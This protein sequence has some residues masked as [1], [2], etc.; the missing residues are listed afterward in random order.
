MH[1]GLHIQ[2]RIFLSDLKFLD[3]FSEKNSQISNFMKIHP[4]G[5]EVSHP[6]GRTDRQ[7]D[8]TKLTVAV[9]SFATTT[10]EK[11]TCL[12][13]DE[14]IPADRNVPQREAERI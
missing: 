3:S 5:Y 12:L 2:Y 9:R 7:T 10:K 1:I 14:T 4:L 8:M 13:I 11:N 6:D